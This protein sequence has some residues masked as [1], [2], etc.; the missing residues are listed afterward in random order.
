VLIRMHDGWHI[1]RKCPLLKDTAMKLLVQCPS[2]AFSVKRL[3]ADDSMQSRLQS[4]SLLVQNMVA[5]LVYLFYSRRT[6]R[7]LNVRF[8]ESAQGWRLKYSGL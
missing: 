4:F 2:T 7:H 6:L 3:S 1:S 5:E 8:D